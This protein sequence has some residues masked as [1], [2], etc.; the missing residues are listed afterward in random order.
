MVVLEQRRGVEADL[1]DRDVHV[2]VPVRAVLDLPR[3]ELRDGLADVVGDGARS[4]GSASGRADRACDR[5]SRPVPSGPES[6]S[7]RRNRES[8]SRSCAM[9]SSA[10]TT[11]APAASASRAASPA[12]NTATRTALPVPFGSET[13]P[14][15]IWSALRGSTPRRNATSTLSSNLRDRQRLHEVERLGRCEELLTVETLR[16]VDECLAVLGHVALL[17]APSGRRVRGRGP[18]PGRGVGF[19]R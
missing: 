3:L 15:I 1:A 8:P 5:A 16:R 14:R 12:A 17:W 6:R 10:P 19:S 9:R 7:R 18:S 11:S 13:V 4:S 2:A